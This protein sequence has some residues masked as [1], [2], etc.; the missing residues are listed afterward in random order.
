MWLQYLD[1]YAVSVDGE[2]MNRKTGEWLTPS[3]DPK[4]RLCVSI[5]SKPKRVH[6]IVAERF[7]PKIDLPGLEV[8]HINR[9]NTDN[10]AVNLRWC[11]RSTNQRNR[12]STNIYYDGNRYRVKFEAK[13][14]VLYKKYFKTLAEA[15]T[16]RDK[17]I[18]TM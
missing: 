7:L 18:S 11:D 5:H 6:K 14:E 10:R 13:G 15:I 8:D 3:Y 9:D 4:G 2:V 1:I 17:F 16:A 12:N